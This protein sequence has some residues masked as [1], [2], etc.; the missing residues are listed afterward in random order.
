MK[1]S[2]GWLLV[3]LSALMFIRTA[4]NPKGI[5]TADAYSKMIPELLIWVVI[6]VAGLCLTGIVKTKK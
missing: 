4:T 2:T 6:G 5:D 1:K 3:I